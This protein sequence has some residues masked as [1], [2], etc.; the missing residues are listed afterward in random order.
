VGAD[1]HTARGRRPIIRE[2]I[3]LYGAVSPKDGNLRLFDYAEPRIRH[4]PGLP[5]V[6]ARKFARQDYLLVLD[7]HP[8]TVSDLPFPTTLRLLYLPPLLAGT[9][10]EEIL[11]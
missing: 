11:G 2:Y 7:G 10:S 6:L 5:R 4:A 3:Y 1:R 9:Q 8:T